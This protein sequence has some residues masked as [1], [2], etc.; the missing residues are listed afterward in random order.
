M[1]ESVVCFGSAARLVGIL[2]PARSPAGDERPAIVLLNSGLI[3]RIAPNRLYVRL[4]R[5]LAALG[6]DCLRF[7][8]SGIG[9][10]SVRRDAL[11]VE[12]SGVAETREAMDLLSE[13][14][15]RRRFVLLGLCGGGYFAFRTALVDERVAGVALLN[16]RGHLHGGDPELG[17]RLEELAQR[18]HYRRI[19]LSPSYRRKNL[20]KILRGEFDRR[21]ALRSLL[22]RHPDDG[23]TV[24]GRRRDLDA[25]DG[26]GVRQLHL[27]SEGDWSL[28]YVEAALGGAASEELSGAGSRF[29]LLPG[30]NHVF[31]PRWSQDEVERLVADW[32]DSMGSGNDPRRTDA[33]AT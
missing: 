33:A 22:R 24:V 4:A 18:A 29:E 5:R 31:T 19:A 9:D 23:A 1:S 15:P 28:D 27:Y 25:L 8:F 32:A 10:S 21:G 7:D 2:T 13:E 16:V 6:H 11:P 14:R 3:H 17:K 20:G 12:E 26:R 30:T